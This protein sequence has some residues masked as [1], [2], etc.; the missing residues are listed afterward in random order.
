MS[1]IM[2][3]K[4]WH[5]IMQDGVKLVLKSEACPTNTIHRNVSRKR[6]TVRQSSYTLVLNNVGMFI[7]ARRK[8]A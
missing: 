6:K 5:G 2:Y 8:K 1:Y 3:A 4:K 7:I